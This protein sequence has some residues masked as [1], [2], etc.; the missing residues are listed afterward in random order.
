MAFFRPPEVSEAFGALDDD[1]FQDGSP[2]SAHVLRELCRNGNRLIAKSS[3]MFR[4]IGDA[5]TSGDNSGSGLGFAP[6][7]WQHLI[8]VPA[9]PVPK[10]YGATKMRVRVRAAITSGATVMVYVGTSRAPTPAHIRSGSDQL[11]CTGA[12]TGTVSVYE[13][14]DI[15]VR[16]DAG[17]VLSFYFRS[18]FDTSTALATGTY[19]G[20]ASGTVAFL[21]GNNFFDD[22]L[23]KNDGW[24]TDV[25]S[26]TNLVDDGHFVLFKDSNGALLHVAQITGTGRDL[27]F[28]DNGS[29]T[30]TTDQLEF[31][32]AARDIRNLAGSTY[33]IYQLP[34]IQMVS[35]AAYSQE[36][37][38]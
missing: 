10:K 17:E 20:N 36:I 31:E 4:W 38:P 15:P 26:N 11:N 2:T 35:V 8:N 18:Y 32:P 27:G 34:R 7:F 14:A 33:E 23:T 22:T 37:E 16:R 12:G 25:P 1:A 21:I 28:I 19:G 3:L 29:Y 5:Q 9:M 13:K 6:F 30:R 24:D